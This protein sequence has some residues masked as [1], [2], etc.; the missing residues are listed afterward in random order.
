[1]ATIDP[2]ELLL[3]LSSAS[4]FGRGLPSSEDLRVLATASVFSATLH[5]NFVTDADYAPGSDERRALQQ[6]FQNGWLHSDKLGDINSPDRIGYF[7]PSPLHRW[8]MEWKLWGKFS[9][10]Q[11]SANGLLDFVINVIRLF[12]PR[13]LL[14]KRRSGLGCIQRSPEAQYQDELYRCCHNFSKGSLITF[15]EFGTAEGRV[16]FYI[17][18]KGWGIELLRDGDRLANH[19]GRF[20]EN[21]LYKTTLDISDY[22]IIDC[23]T[24]RPR[25]EHARK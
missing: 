18:A 2:Q 5:R 13:H 11:F 10:A 19:C 14:A 1:M 21:G 24:T 16:D 4:I 22:I 3:R 8:Y 25:K 7:F 6:C 9:Q 17:P 15:P 23:R 12:S 20:S